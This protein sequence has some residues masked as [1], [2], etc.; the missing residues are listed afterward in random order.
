MVVVERPVTGSR[1]MVMTFPFRRIVT[2]EPGCCPL[3]SSTL[4]TIAVRADSIAIGTMAWT[5]NHTAAVA[6]AQPSMTF[7]LNS[8]SGLYGSGDS[9]GSTAF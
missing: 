9:T 3:T 5:A 1:V 6:R 2:V 8:G 4:S 7:L